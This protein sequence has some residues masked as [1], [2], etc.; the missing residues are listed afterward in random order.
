MI[1]ASKVGICYAILVGLLC[2]FGKSGVYI[3]GVIQEVFVMTIL[4]GFPKMHPKCCAVSTLETSREDIE[5]YIEGVGQ[6]DDPV[7]V[8]FVHRVLLG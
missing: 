3:R 8:G 4:R 5:A 6:N 7:G 2:N 1:Q